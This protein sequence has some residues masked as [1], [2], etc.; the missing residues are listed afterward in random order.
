[1]PVTKVNINLVNLHLLQ[2]VKT[3]VNITGKTTGGTGLLQKAILVFAIII[4]VAGCASDS[5]KENLFDTVYYRPEYAGGFEIAGMKGGKSRVIRV[6]AAWQGADSSA[7]ELFIARDSEKPPKGFK[8]QVIDGNAERIAVMSSSYIAMLDLIGETDKVV[9]VSGLKYISNEH[10]I[11]NRDKIADI[12]YENSTDYEKLASTAPD[13]VLLYGINASNAIETHLNSLGIPYLYMGEYLETAPLGR[14][15]WAVA[16]AE[17]AG[18]F[19]K[20]IS[21]FKTVEKEY[22]RLKKLIDN[23]LHRPKVMLNVP[24]GDTWFM[25]PGASAMATLIK[26]AGADYVYGKDTGNKTLPIDIEEAYL[27]ASDSDFWLNVGQM[28]SIDELESAYPKFRNIKCIKNGNVYNCNKRVTASGGND[29]WESGLIRPDIVLS[30]LISIF[31]P[32]ISGNER[33]AEEGLYYYKRL[34]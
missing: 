30:D 29:F 34:G 20:G 4:S 19:E 27:L 7:F 31:H 22:S 25:T 28:D 17:I 10:I 21:A 18:S 16:L 9:A 32:E 1:M 12:G 15:E 26:D 13:L 5:K 8:G 33:S 14:A 2:Q 3:K 23:S 6:A 11:E 24:Y